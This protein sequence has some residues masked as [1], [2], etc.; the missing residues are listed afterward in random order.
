MDRCKQSRLGRVEE[1]EMLMCNV[2]GETE[3]MAW[4]ARKICVGSVCSTDLSNCL[5]VL[6]EVQKARIKSGAHLPG[7]D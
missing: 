3:G 5:G 6:T 4:L 1:E 7:K 2:Q